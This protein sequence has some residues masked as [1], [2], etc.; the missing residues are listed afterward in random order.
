MLTVE[1]SRIRKSLRAR[2][3]IEYFIYRSELTE[4]LKNLPDLTIPNF[5]VA[6]ENLKNKLSFI[7]QAF[8]AGFVI[9]PETENII[10]KMRKLSEATEGPETI[11]PLD[12]FVFRTIIEDCKLD[13]DLDDITQATQREWTE[14]VRQFQHLIDNNWNIVFPKFEDQLKLRQD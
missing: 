1:A 11:E 13:F 3:E 2:K 6:Y 9:K 7:K 10:S 12:A 14:K 4:S 8:N 5:H